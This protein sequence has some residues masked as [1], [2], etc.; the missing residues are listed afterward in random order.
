[1]IVVAVI[2]TAQEKDRDSTPGIHPKEL[3]AG[4]Q[5]DAYKSMSIAT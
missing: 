4:T 1:M 5:T 3:K 2:S